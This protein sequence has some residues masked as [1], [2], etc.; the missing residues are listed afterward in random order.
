MNGNIYIYSLIYICAR[1]QEAAGLFLVGT[2]I[3]TCVLEGA[4]IASD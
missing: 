4:L 1:C 3:V 2:Y